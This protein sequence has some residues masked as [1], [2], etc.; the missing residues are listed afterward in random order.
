MSSPDLAGVEAKI[1]RADQ[2]LTELQG[3]TDRLFRDH[4]RIERG[5]DVES[6][7]YRFT[8]LGAHD[9][10]A[11]LAVIVG[12]IVHQLRS[13]LD[14]VVTQ[15]H[16]IGPGGGDPTKLAFPICRTPQ[17]FTAAVDRG[18]LRGLPAPMIREISAVQPYV[19]TPSQPEQATLWQ[20]HE[21]D[22]VDKHR[23]LAVVVAAVQFP[24]KVGIAATKAMTITGISPPPNFRVRPSPAGA[25]VF[26]IDFVE[27]DP[28]M[29]IDADCQFELTFGGPALLHDLPVLTVLTQMRARV[30][31]I[32]R[33][34]CFSRLR[35]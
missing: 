7:Q 2:H 27:S 24:G 19:T 3:E 25:V 13:S 9:V 29:H 8:A 31:D 6:R 21:L 14:H 15:L 10:P 34:R 11:R 20:L 17:Q 22:I 35:A 30:V 18:Q 4:Y 28:G 23:I 26:S 16:E 32:I 5:F 12:E 1:R 33:T